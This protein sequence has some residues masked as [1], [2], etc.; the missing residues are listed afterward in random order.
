VSMV[1]GRDGIEVDAGRRDRGLGL[2]VVAL[3]VVAGQWTPGFHAD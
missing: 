2:R 3:R 1:A